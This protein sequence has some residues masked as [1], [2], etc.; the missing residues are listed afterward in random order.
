MNGCMNQSS[1]NVH[2]S[3][4]AMG[5]VLLSLVILLLV[6]WPFLRTADEPPFG[7]A[8]RVP[9]TDSRVIG[10]PDPPLPYNVERT[11]TNLTWQ[12]PIFITAEPGTDRLFVIQ[13]GGESNKPSRI[14]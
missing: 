3:K 1:P 8:R 9:W 7:L 14:L 11:F 10:S 4:R 12:R 2:G 13:Q 6:G 5:L